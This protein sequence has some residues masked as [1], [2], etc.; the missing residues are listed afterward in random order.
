MNL[1][2]SSNVVRVG[3]LGLALA[4]GCAGGLTGCAPEDPAAIDPIEPPTEAVME[5]SE[6]LS[7]AEVLDVQRVHLDGDVYHYSLLFKVGAA[8]NARLRIHRVVREL[9]PWQPRSSASSVMLLHGDFATFTTSFAPALTGAAKPPS[10]GM[11]VYL[12]KK[13][14]DVWGVDRRWTT[15]PTSGADLSDF[16]AMTLSQE[17]DDI[18]GALAFAR[19]SRA[20]MGSGPGRMILA[21]FSHGGQLAYEYAARESQLPLGQR[22]LRGLIPLD[23]YARISPADAEFRQ[24]AC[25]S[26]YY[27]HDALAQGVVDSDNG[28]QIQVGSLDASAPGDPSPLFDGLTNRG[29]LY[30]LMTKTYQFYTPTP[31]YHLAG[32][33]LV[34]DEPTALRYSTEPAID[35]WLSNAPFHQSLAESADADAMWCGDGP[36]PL[37]DHLADITVPL[38]YLGAAGGFGDH[39]LYTTTLV[40]STDV[41]T[42][43]I[44]RL[45]PAQEG[46]DFGHAD[47]LFAGDAPDLAWQPLAQWILQH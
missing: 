19:I 17:L 12:A 47:L 26:S 37:A 7:Q 1:L 10:G 46:E 20:A 41:T 22:H 31:L 32:G 42:K 4:L 35:A 24:N 33:V 36:L 3:G 45:A 38:F 43:V 29:A 16:G 44:R 14:V 28:F 15:A 8:P 9:G 25:I 34:N 27:E 6:P 5:A 13:N 23:I 40:A 11:A 30:A 39:G 21:G 18:G 2:M